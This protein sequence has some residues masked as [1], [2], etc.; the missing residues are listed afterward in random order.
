M[1]GNGPEFTA[2]TNNKQ[3]RRNFF[4]YR[5]QRQQQQQQESSRFMNNNSRL[6]SYF[7]SLKWNPI[8]ISV[9]VGFLV[10]QQYRKVLRRSSDE[11]TGGEQGQ[12]SLRQDWEVRKKSLLLN[13][14]EFGFVIKNLLLEIPKI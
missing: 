8:P 6:F 7:R 1:V 2:G 5:Q 10:F 12:I 9:G 4:T 13:S 14:P 11:A 3:F